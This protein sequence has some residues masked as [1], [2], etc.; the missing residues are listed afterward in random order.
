MLLFV[1]FIECD[2]I[3]KVVNMI[4]ISSHFKEQIWFLENL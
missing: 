4:I 3:Q 1:Q 2:E